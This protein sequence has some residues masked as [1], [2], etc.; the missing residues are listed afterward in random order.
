MS[1]GGER[2]SPVDTTWLGMDRSTNLMQIVALVVLA[3]PVDPDRLE[4][5][6]VERLLEI[7]RFR[8]RPEDQ[9]GTMHW[10]Q[11]P[12]LDLTRHVRRLRL[13]G[14]GGKE[15]L[16]RF[17]AE[18]ASTPLDHDH[19]L[20]QF[21]IVEDYASGGAAVV[22]RVHHA[23]GD[24][25]ALLSVLLSLTD[26]RE[27]AR[28]TR[29]SERQAR[30]AS[31]LLAPVLEVVGDGLRLSGEAWRGS[32]DLLREPES[33]IRGGAAIAGELGHLLLMPMDSNT[34]FKGQLSGSKR[35][36]WSEPMA[37]PEV[38]VVG[39]ALGCSIN[40]LL[41]AAAAGALQGYLAEKGDETEGVAIRALVPV[42][43]R[44]AG[45]ERELGN[46]FGIVAIE[47]PLGLNPLAR[48]YE[49]HRRM[50]ALK[51]SYEAPV[52]LGLLAALGYA[53][54]VVQD[55]VFDL[56]LSRATAVMT[57]V[58]GPQ[59]ELR[60]AGSSITELMFWVPQAGEIG[61]GLSILSY[62]GKVQFGL[63]TDSALVPDPEA[64]AARFNPEFEQL[65]YFVLLEG[66]GSEPHAVATKSKK[67]AR[68]PESRGRHG[69]RARSRTDAKPPR[70]QH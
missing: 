16:Q 37:L 36:A 21:H 33:A 13:P 43:L 54:K 2:I 35:V 1:L 48:L 30:S 34:R 66:S 7:S 17:V 70:K 57:N 42:N 60:I 58:P 20:W 11:E 68:K 59:E 64:I 18:L 27:T 49:V 8:E 24:G 53:P 26:D 55:Q 62:N 46:R 39:Q 38:S 12:Y 44:P 4:T 31:G 14:R 50:D 41:L 40:D 10:V 15:R 65:L 63:M 56:L 23:V 25:A 22:F 5:T 69:A 45:T 61:M 29:P 6:L 67:P 28:P 51:E 19:P 9:S 32:L 3:P 52:T 47:L